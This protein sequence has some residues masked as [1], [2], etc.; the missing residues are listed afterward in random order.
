MNY[1]WTDCVLK[2]STCQR[3]TCHFLQHSFL[4]ITRATT[5]AINGRSVHFTGGPRVQF[6]PCL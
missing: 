4:H 6:P 2:V 3:A 5:E 1:I